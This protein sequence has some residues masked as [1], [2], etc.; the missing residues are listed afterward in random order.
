M[1]DIGGVLDVVGGLLCLTAAYLFS[2]GAARFRGSSII[3]K[4]GRGLRPRHLGA[5]CVLCGVRPPVFWSI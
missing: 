3:P 4:F 5:L 1:N 2:E